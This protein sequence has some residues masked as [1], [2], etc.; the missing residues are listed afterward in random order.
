MTALAVSMGA[1]VQKI[2]VTVIRHDKLGDA[3]GD[4]RSNK[5]EMF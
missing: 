1:A 5:G 3:D 4:G 2:W